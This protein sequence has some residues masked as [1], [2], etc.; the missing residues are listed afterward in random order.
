MDLTGASAIVTGGAGGF[1]SATV[2]RLVEAGAK[3]VIADLADERANALA[4]ELG[5]SVRYVRT[6]V[7][8]DESVDAAIAVAKELGELRAA[9]IVHGGAAGG[10]PS[11]IL[12]REGKTYPT[13]HFAKTID[14]YLTASFR[15]LSKVAEAMATYEPKDSGQRGVIIHT[16]SIAGFEGQVG[17]S[18]YSA[19]KGGIIGLNLTA[20]RDLAP[21]GIRVMSIA[22]GVMLTPAYG[23][24]TP[25]AL[26]E[27]FKIP[28]PKRPG[29]PDEY[30]RLALHI[31]DND[32]L[33]GHVIRLDAALRF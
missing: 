4:A 3:V 24:V 18:S 13:S 33:N 25:E 21:V 7:T 8:S 16:A 2:Q 23:D 29:I 20:A 15:V 27:R 12:N 17:Q 5:D 9:V 26:Q 1:G 30:A 32:Y 28:N 11:R 22:P 6:D 14:I 31:I 10:P 19:A